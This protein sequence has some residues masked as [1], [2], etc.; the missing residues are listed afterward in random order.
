MPRM[1]SGLD[2]LPWHEIQGML[3]D[4]FWNIGIHIRVH[5]LPFSSQRP[6]SGPRRDNGSGV[7]SLYS[8]Y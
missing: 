1:A 7:H 2:E 5:Y 4:I 8:L 6:L 3:V